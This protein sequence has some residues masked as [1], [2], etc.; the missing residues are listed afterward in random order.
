MFPLLT[1]SKIAQLPE[2]K[3]RFP[4]PPAEKNV[5]QIKSTGL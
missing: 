2:T 4:T 1:G 5:P 3:L